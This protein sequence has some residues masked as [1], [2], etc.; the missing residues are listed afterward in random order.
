MTRL[1]VGFTRVSGANKI[2]LFRIIHPASPVLIG[3]PSLRALGGR[4]WLRFS[5]LP[6]PHEQSE[7]WVDDVFGVRA[8][9]G[10]KK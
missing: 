5:I 4:R 3:C 1:M 8:F 7:R 6:P 10:T 2:Q 9:A